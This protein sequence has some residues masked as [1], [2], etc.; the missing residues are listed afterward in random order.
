MAVKTG[1]IE[2]V[3]TPTEERLPLL[4]E[5]YLDTGLL[6]YLRKKLWG[7]PLILK[8]PKG[9]GKTLA[10]EQLCAELEVPMVRHPCTE[11]DTT[12]DLFGSKRIDG[13]F[14][15]GAITE[16]IDIANEEGACVLVLE[17]VNALSPRTQKA[18]NSVL[19][20]RKEVGL[21]KIGVVFRVNEKSLL[22]VVGT[23]NPNYSGTY[24]LNEDLNSRFTLVQVGYM[25]EKLE[26]ALLR[27]ELAHT[28]KRELENTERRTVDGIHRVAV[29][30]RSGEMNY[31]LSTR[32]LITLMHSWAQHGSPEPA[33]KEVEGKY[34]GEHV[35]N[36]QAR[37]ASTLKI[38]LTAVVLF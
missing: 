4:N 22:W 15:L 3:R 31:A 35:K 19:D 29:E 38:D 9:S 2:Y 14:Q 1:A 30:T 5:R 16:A 11:D 32:D 27:E 33:L 21:A 18:L 12:R 37:V 28:L 7:D 8:G 34:E 20:Y 6:G 36:F 17:E 24:D 26:L 25:P 10:I 13:R 23:M